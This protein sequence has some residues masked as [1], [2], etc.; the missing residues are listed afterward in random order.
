[1]KLHSIDSKPSEPRRIE[2]LSLSPYFIPGHKG[3]GPAKSV[4]YLLDNTHSSIRI[5]LITSDRDLG[6]RQP[7]HGLSGTL[8]EYARHRVFYLNPKSPRQWRRLLRI[9]SRTRFDILYLNSTFSPTYS[10]IPLL[11]ARL[12]IVRV[13]GVVI[14]P[15]GEFSS[16]ALTIKRRKKAVFI[17]LTRRPMFGRVLWHA[18]TE[19]EMRDILHV[20][21]AARVLTVLNSAG[22]APIADVIPSGPEVRVVFIGR[23]TPKKNLLYALRVLESIGADLTLDIFGPIEDAEYWESCTEVMNRLPPR[24]R[25]EYKGDLPPHMVLTTLSEYDA[26]LFP[27]LGENF[28]HV[29]L[30]ALA[31]G[32]PVFCSDQTPWTPLLESGAGRALPLAD[33]DAWASAIEGLVRD[34]QAQRTANKKL[35]L[36]VYGSWR[37]NTEV[38]DLFQRVWCALRPTAA[39]SGEHETR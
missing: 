38:D 19:L 36:T 10:L 16:G 33:R 23:L 31:T 14:A 17:A 28:G 29:I 9:A 26:F 37:A 32:C 2:V 13:E 7:Y 12:R 39:S 3:G 8:Q 35:A 30:E 21:P 34:S 22:D 11:L 15:R 24:V 4:K 27:T 6:D 18:S 20:H 25:V 1:M 5:T